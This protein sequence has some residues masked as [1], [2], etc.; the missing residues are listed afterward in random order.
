MVETQTRMIRRLDCLR[1]HHPEGMVAVVGHGDPLRSAVAF[2]LGIPL[3]LILRFEISP[4]S[5]TVV[6]TGDWGARVICLNET[7]EVPV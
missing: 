2:F 6:E 5:V 4:A 3:D 1:K 7:G